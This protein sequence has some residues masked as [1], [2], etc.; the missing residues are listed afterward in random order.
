MG[1]ALFAAAGAWPLATAGDRPA[2]AAVVLPYTLLWGMANAFIQPSLFASSTW[3]REQSSRGWFL[4][5]AC[6]SG[7]WAV[8]VAVLGA[9][10]G[11]TLAGLHRARTVVL[12]TATMTAVA[13][14]ATAGG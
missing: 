9:H 3:R 14:L 12:I 11:T 7:S 10:P 1:A 2:Y 13:G 5:M 6:D 8:F 4:S